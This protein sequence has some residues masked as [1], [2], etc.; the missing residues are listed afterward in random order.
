MQADS[1]IKQWQAKVNSRKNGLTK[2][3]FEMSRLLSGHKK[4][5]TLHRRL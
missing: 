4:L 5:F 2:S 3:A 1:K